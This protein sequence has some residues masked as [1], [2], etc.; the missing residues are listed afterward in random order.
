M[1]YKGIWHDI[2]TLMGSRIGSQ[3]TKEHLPKNLQNIKANIFFPATSQFK[4]TSITLSNNGKNRKNRGHCIVIQN[5]EARTIN[6]I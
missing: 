5:V 4:E 1:H 6:N 2:K 3:Q